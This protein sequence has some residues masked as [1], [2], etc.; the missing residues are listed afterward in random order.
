MFISKTS[1]TKFGQFLH[2]ALRTFRDPLIQS[3]FSLILGKTFKNHSSLI[4]NFMTNI[5]V[6]KMY[7]SDSTRLK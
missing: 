5:S 6:Y 2:L 7:I 4:W 1:I 3:N